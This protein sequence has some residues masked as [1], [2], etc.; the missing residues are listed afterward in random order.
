MVKAVITKK[1]WK[2]NSELKAFIFY[3]QLQY[4]SCKSLIHNPDFPIVTEQHRK[5]TILDGNI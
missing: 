1:R 2:R 4:E 5:A 3:K